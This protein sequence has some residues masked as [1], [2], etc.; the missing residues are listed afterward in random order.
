MIY[1]RKAMKEP[2][3]KDF[4]TAMR[5]EIDNQIDKG[6]L[7][8]VRRKNAKKGVPVLP[9]V[10]KMKQ[11]RDILTR[12]VEKYKARLNLDR[13]RMVHKCGYDETYA[14]VAS[15]GL[16]LLVLVITQVHEWYSRQLD[17]ACIASISCWSDRIFYPD[18][19]VVVGVGVLGYISVSSS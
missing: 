12:E 2:N 13:S 11:K 4:R 1:H 5:K 17:Y 6:V 19:V 15:W 7:E 10:W 8:L 16:V 3:S 14:P 9:A 18:C